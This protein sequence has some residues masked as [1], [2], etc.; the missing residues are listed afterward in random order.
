MIPNNE[1][2]I[3]FH[4]DENQIINIEKIMQRDEVID[5]EFI[6]NLS[7][8]EIEKIKEKNNKILQKNKNI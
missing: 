2:N 6:T 1:I 3:L 5:F 4:L 8:Q 7:D